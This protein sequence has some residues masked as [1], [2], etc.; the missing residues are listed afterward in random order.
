MCGSCRRSFG[1]RIC[2]SKHLSPVTATCCTTCGSR[3][4][5]QAARYLNLNF[6]FLLCSW[7]IALLLL[8]LLMAN[9]ATVFGLA[10][11]AADHVFSF[12][13]GKPVKQELGC[14][15]QYA[16]VFGL[17]WIAIRRIVG[18]DSGVVKAAERLFG[19][20]FRRLPR[21]LLWL[22]RGLVKWI[23]FRPDRGKTS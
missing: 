18:K 3:K 11:E 17:I 7:A 22:A 8:K 9:L 21:V 13:L 5:S 14:L 2:S 4:L 10:I 1:G 23:S 20:V 6:S 16:I 15:L 19:Q 12:V